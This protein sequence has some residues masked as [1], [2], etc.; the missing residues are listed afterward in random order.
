MLFMLFNA[1]MSFVLALGLIAA[2]RYHRDH[3]TEDAALSA[4]IAIVCAS[5]F[6]AYVMVLG[7][8]TVFKELSK[9]VR[10]VFGG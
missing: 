2:Y 9:L 1:F 10:L 3:R 5:V 6:C 4:F 7:F 8:S